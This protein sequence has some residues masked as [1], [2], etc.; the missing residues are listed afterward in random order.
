MDSKA[1][2]VSIHVSIVSKELIA[3]FHE[4]GLKTLSWTVNDKK[5]LLKHMGMGV[6]GVVTDRP[7]LVLSVIKSKETLH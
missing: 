4:V 5:T 7:D 3:L 1:D 6:D 2:M